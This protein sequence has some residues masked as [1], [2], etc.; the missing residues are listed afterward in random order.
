ML[1]RPSQ[2]ELFRAG[3]ID[4]LNLERSHPLKF[5]PGN[6]L[7]K[8]TRTVQIHLISI[9]FEKLLPQGGKAHA[10]LL[11]RETAS[12]PAIDKR[13]TPKPLTTLVHE[14]ERRKNQGSRT[15]QPPLG[16]SQLKRELLLHQT[17]PN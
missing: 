14:F 1:F 11:Q 6:L 7:V 5:E 13:A 9:L 2:G 12:T 17:Q 15:F 8:T 3:F 10:T 4:R 16:I